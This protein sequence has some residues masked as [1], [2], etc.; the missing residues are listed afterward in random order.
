LDITDWAR[1]HPASI[2]IRHYRPAGETLQLKNA[3]FE[4]GDAL[5]TPRYWD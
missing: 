5:V 3:R 1:T 4:V 2:A